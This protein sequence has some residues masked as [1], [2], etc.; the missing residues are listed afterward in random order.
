[1]LDVAPDVSDLNLS[2]RA[3]KCMNRLELG[4]I[5]ELLRA[6]IDVAPAVPHSSAHQVEDKGYGPDPKRLRARRRR[7]RKPGW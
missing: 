7:H 2:V 5:G 4:S 6:L 3:R 1:M